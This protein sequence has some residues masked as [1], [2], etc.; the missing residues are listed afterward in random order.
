M[1]KRLM[2]ALNLDADGAVR[3]T[4]FEPAPVPEVLLS[5]NEREAMESFLF[6]ATS[7]AF[8]YIDRDGRKGIVF[9]DDRGRAACGV[10]RDMDD[11]LL[12]GLAQREGYEYVPGAVAFM[13]DI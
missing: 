7:S 12:L 8:R 4:E 5:P 13:G 3:R 6:D 2:E 1:L 11:G 10:V 9:Y